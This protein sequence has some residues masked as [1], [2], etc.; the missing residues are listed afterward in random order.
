MK[1]H[2]I[3]N[4]AVIFIAAVTFVLFAPVTAEASRMH[5]QRWDR[6]KKLVK[7]MK[8]K[9]STHATSLIFGKKSRR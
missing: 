4:W 1:V 3:T 6:H 7:I 2:Y 9:K 5:N 8:E